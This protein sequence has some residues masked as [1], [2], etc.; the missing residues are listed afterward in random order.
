M[1]KRKK[2]SCVIALAMVLSATS[3]CG[4]EASVEAATVT[5]TEMITADR[6]VA[7]GDTLEISVSDKTALKGAS[8]TLG[9][10]ATLR[11]KGK[12]IGENAVVMGDGSEH[13]IVTIKAATNAKNTKLVIG[14]A[15]TTAPTN[16]SVAIGWCGSDID[17]DT[18]EINVNSGGK[19]L[20]MSRHDSYSA[21]NESHSIKARKIDLYSGGAGIFVSGNVESG[22]EIKITDFEDC[23][24]NTLNTAISNEAWSGTKVILRGSDTGTLTI[25]TRSASCAINLSDGSINQTENYR[26]ANQIDVYAGT[27]TLKND[28]YR[29]GNEVVSVSHGTLNITA[30][31][32]IVIHTNSTRAIQV[33][34]IDLLQGK[35]HGILNINTDQKAT[36]QITGGIDHNNGE[37]KLFLKDNQSYI[38]G[39]VNTVENSDIL[40]ANDARIENLKLNVYDDVFDS[41]IYKLRA[42]NGVIRTS[43]DMT[44]KNYEGNATVIYGHNESDPT[45]INGGDVKIE[46]A[47]PGSTITVRTDPN[48]VALN[49]SDQVYHVLN[50]IAGKIYYIEHYTEGK[51]D[52]TGYAQLAEGLTTAA[53]TV[54]ISD[55]KF[56]DDNGQGYI[57]RDWI[58]DPNEE[59]NPN[60]DDEDDMPN[61]DVIPGDDETAIMQGVKSAHAAL[62]SMWRSENQDMILRMGEV[63]DGKD[64]GMW[65][66]YTHGKQEMNEQK[67][68][69]KTSYN[70]YQI[71]YD[72]RVDANWLIGTAFSY[73]EGD[74]AYRYGGDGDS[75][76]AG[77]SF[78]GTKK[79]AGDAFLDIVA[80]VSRLD[81]DYTVYNDVLHRLDGDYNTWGA[82]ISA[83]VGKRY[84][85]KRGAYIEP[86]VQITL[87]QVHSKSYRAHSDMIGSNG[88]AKNMYIDQDAFNSLVARVGI[89]AGQITERYNCY[90][91]LS[92]AHEFCGNLV[93]NFRAD[94]ERDAQTRLDLSDTWCELQVGA[95]TQLNDTTMLYAT[96]RS[97]FGAKVDEKYRIDGGLRI[98]F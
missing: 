12:A 19:L 15:N 86:N 98:S 69:F 57:E 60:P 91:K 43:A 13:K 22:K 36:V 85:Q 78:Y 61:D 58:R 74:H 26:S 18:L 89:S 44:I 1:M 48:G 29:P 51:N 53:T 30:K 33:K 76:I 83:E 3:I 70:Q 4:Y 95:G 32:S 59:I 41:N 31:D 67:T 64:T 46:S 28:T 82:S 68:K 97:N 79:F 49:D 73:N 52:L 16:G 94:E 81:H 5:E 54:R 20:Q 47:K 63:R 55:M 72:K 65:M 45:L 27:V 24:I 38:K 71:G 90:A 66:K 6:T 37:L 9:D 25:K 84:Q 10:G 35:S 96:Y 11:L 50:N 92:V 7:A 87:G 40:L 34:G 80:K 75:R 23:M 8:V 14:D 62:L 77:L 21:Y 2:L 93:T 42:Q 39:Y 56:K 88:Q 17:V